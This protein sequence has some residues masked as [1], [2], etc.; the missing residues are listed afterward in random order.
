MKKFLKPKGFWIHVWILSPIFRFLLRFT[1]KR[2]IFNVVVNGRD[3]VPATGPVIVASNHLSYAD[4]PCL[5][6]AL[7]RNAVFMAAKELWYNPLFGWVL[8]LMRHIPVDRKSRKSGEKAKKKFLGHL[9]AGGMGIIYPEGKIS[10][11]GELLAFKR[12]VYDLALESGAL[13]VP[14]GVVGTNRLLPLRSK[15]I[16]R[17]EPV[18][19]NFGEGIFARDFASAES[20]LT[21]LRLRIQALSGQELEEE[22]E[23]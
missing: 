12:G 7:R 14:G 17:R 13:V 23:E 16:N 22:K 21:E 15:K 1:V 4:P 2:G 11:T 19:M 9:R 20:F 18:T 6:G 8:I 3:N 5:W 10:K